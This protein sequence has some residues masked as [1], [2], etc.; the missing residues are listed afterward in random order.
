[1]AENLRNWARNYEYEAATLHRPTSV[2]QVREIVSKAHRVKALGTR[3]SFNAIADTAEDQISTEHLNQIVTI[4]REAM[5][6]TVEGGIAYG[7][8]SERLHAEGLAVH[9]L[10]SLPHISV[11]G[12]TATATH[13]S[14]DANGNLATA[15]AGLD[16]VK[17][18]GELVSL[19]RGDPD[20]PG[21]VVNLGA[22]GVVVRVTLDLKPTFLVAQSVYEHLPFAEL[23]ANFDAITSEA[24]SVSLFTAWAGPTVDQVWIKRLFTEA[25]P[26]PAT[27]H[28]ARL[29]LDRRHPIRDIS[30][31]NCTAQMG[32]PGPS[33]DRLPHFRMDFTPSSGEE[34][35]AEYLIPRRHALEAVKT[36]NE[37]R[38]LI[39]PHLLIS[40]IRTMAADGL[41]LSPAYGEGSVGIHFTLKPDWEAARQM[42]PVVDARLA[43]LGAR[44]HWGKL[45]TMAP[46]QF[47][48]LYT[49]LEDFRALARRFDPEGKFRNAYL[50]RNIFNA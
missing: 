22:L 42:L 37:M 31:V 34:L 16:I 49:R 8:L 28:G 47:Q 35:Q 33:H 6:V 38:D 7:R 30:P 26:S 20:F 45:F 46:E 5:Q 48:P 25:A 11:A 44:P 10:A 15:V 27:F 1:M 43:P 4:D 40:E 23:E 19:K 2:E 36:V 50:D 41:W 39:A 13:G 3:H 14:G 18:D 24:Y 12:A 29:A 9:N 21:A 32:E 17:A